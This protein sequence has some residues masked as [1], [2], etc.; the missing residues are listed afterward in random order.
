MWLFCGIGL[1]R[2]PGPRFSLIVVVVVVVWKRNEVQRAGLPDNLL[3]SRS[4][5][6][7]LLFKV[8]PRFC[9]R[10]MPEAAAAAP[11]DDRRSAAA[12]ANL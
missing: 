8:S 12:V 4:L 5:N 3:T 9:S 2:R 11:C 7:L 6:R 10:G 1:R